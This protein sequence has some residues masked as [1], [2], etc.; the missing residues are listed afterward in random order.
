MTAETPDRLDDRRLARNPIAIV[1][2]SGLFP[3]ARNHREYW[4]NIVDGIDCTEDVPESRWSLDEY[5]DE[6]RTAPDKTYSRRGA[7]LPDVDFDPLEFGL[8][9]NQ[10]EVTSTMQTLSLGVARDLLTDAGAPDS[11]WYDPS[12]TGVVLGI[13]GPVP[14]MHPLAARLSTPV[15]KEVARSCGLSDTDANVLADKFVTAFAPWEENSFPGL[16]ANVVAGR[17]ANRFGLGGINCT[18]DAACAASLAAMRTA[19]AELLDGR[20]DTMITGGVDT[21]NSIFIYM[22]F[23]KVGALSPTGRISPFSDQANGTLL[24]EGISMLALRRLEDAERDGNRIY[25]VIKGLGSSSDGRSKSIYAPRAEG[26]RVA[27]DRAYTDADCSPAS[28]ELFEAHATGTA[29]GD[30]TELTALGGLLADSSDEHRFAALGSVKSQIGHTKGAAGTASVMKLALGLYHRVL[31]GTINVDKP[32]PAIDTAAA[33]Y[34]INTRTRP[35]IRDPQ[36]PVRRAA[37]SAM[38]FGGTNFHVVL[39][40]HANPAADRRTLHTAPTAHLW[41]AP[42]VTTLTDLVR[43]RPSQDGGQIPTDHVRIG[44][45]SLDDDNETHLRE[46]AADQLAKNPDAKAWNHPEGIFY[47]AAAQP[48]LRIGALFSGQGSQ[49]VDMGTAAVLANPLVADTFD[50]ANAAFAGEPQRLG[51]V[52]FPPPVFDDSD[53]D[54]QEALLRRTEFAQPAIGALSAGQFRALTELGFHA[55]G[56]LGHSFGE[57]TALW[58]AGSLTTDD[59]FTLARARG[60][61]MAPQ[62]GAETGTMLAV[63]ATRDDVDTLIADLDDV[64]VCNHNA[65]DQIVVGGGAEAVAAFARTCA[66]RGF[67]TR[68]LPVSA[69]FHTPYVGHAV[70]AFEP[71]VAEV[72]IGEPAAP[73]YAN[74]PGAHYG[75]DIDTNRATLVG[76]LL[77]PVEFVTA[78]DSMRQA[79]CTVFV[80]FG[81][82]QVLTSLVRRTLGDDVV[83]IAT[84]GGPLGDSDLSL[85]RAAV[86][87]A[88]LGLALDG[89]NRYQDLPPVPVERRGMSVSLSAPE[90]IPEERRRA[91][92]DAL[93]D[94]YRVAPVTAPAASTLEPTATHPAPLPIPPAPPVTAAATPMPFRATENT[95]SHPAGPSTGLDTALSQ[96][97]A[98]HNDYLDGQLELARE[99]ARALNTAQLDNGMVRAIEA[100]KD[101]G[102]A[103]SHT[104]A[105]ATEILGHL[106]ELDTPAATGTTVAVSSRVDLE[107]LPTRPAPAPTPAPAPAPAPIPAPVP[108]PTPAAAPPAPTTP[109]TPTAPPATTAPAQP[110]AVDAAALRTALQEVVADKTGYPVEMVDPSMDL[111]ADLGVDSIKRV[112]V[113]GAVQERFPHLPSLGPEQ[114]GTLRTLDQI[115]DLLADTAAPAA[116]TT[117]PTSSPP[118]GVDA[119]VLR[120]ALQEVVADKTGYPVEMVD[121]SMDLEADLGVD[122]IKRVQVLGAVQERFPHLPSL[123]PEQLGTLRTLD[124]IVDL[125][126]EGS[127]VHPKAEAAATAPRHLVELVALP[128]IDHQDNTFG[129]HPHAVVI[130]LGPDQESSDG[131]A[132]AD[133][134]TNHHWTVRRIP[135]TGTLDDIDT[136]LTGTHDERTDLCIVTVGS[137]HD[138]AEA[139]RALGAT[140]LA[141]KHTHPALLNTARTGTR[142]AFVTVT[143]IDGALG[144]VGAGDPV[145]ALAGGVGGVVKTL[146]VEHPE[147]FSRAL[148][149]HPALDGDRFTTAVLAELHDSAVDTPE[150]GVGELGDRQTLVPGI[151][152]GSAEQT[153][154]H[155]NTPVEITALTADDVVLVTGGARGVTALC[156][157]DLARHCDARFILLGR[158]ELVPEPQWAHGVEDQDLRRAAI[159]GLGGTATTPREIARTCAAITANREI[160]DTLT[161]LGERGRYIAA[162]VTDTAAIE[163]ALGADRD[164]ITA[165]VHGAGVLADALIAKKTAGEIARVL[166]PKVGGLAAVLGALG[167]TAQLRHLV[168]FTSVAGLYGN[169]GQVDYA[170]ANEALGRFAATW[171]H[172]HPDHHVTAI[173]WGAWDGGMVTPELRGYFLDRGI[174][175]LDPDVGARAFTEQFTTARRDDVVILIGEAKSLATGQPSHRPDTIVRRNLSD[176]P[177]HRIIAAHRIGDHT[178]LPATFGLGAMINVV[179]RAHPG[180]CVTTVRDFRVHKGIVFDHPITDV[181]IETTHTDDNEPVRVHVQVFGT[182]NDRRVPHYAATFELSTTPDSAPAVPVTWPTTGADAEILYRDA[183]QFH[184]PPLQGMRR[185]LRDDADALVLECALSGAPVALGAFTGVLHNPVLADVILQGPP[186]AG[187]RALGSACLPLGIGRIDYYDALPDDEPFVLIVDNARRGPVD[188]LVDACAVTANGTVL[189]RFTDVTV[190]TTPDLSE[191]F[192]ES[193]RQWSA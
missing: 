97:V 41:H 191:K 83:A 79:G 2:M 4:Q 166:N 157:R 93:A 142:A 102:V 103:I 149:I 58:A 23:S 129:D 21:E 109:A 78:L 67:A 82:K 75:T 169:S 127:D 135:L 100:I 105:R 183:T 178:V 18:V 132:I 177:A 89:I 86:Q 63:A 37:A 68:E 54:T 114:L 98:T 31:P 145:G 55:D 152:A 119:A 72:R 95:V 50:R 137:T 43:S 173:D 8:P 14:L 94:G 1:G 172:R 121:P 34:Y 158:T 22:C 181:S 156:V 90:Y 136:T 13:T 3:K 66:D 122:S 154:V 153:S 143:R 190:V 125:L 28:V 25:A 35:W 192:R 38:G 26:Q 134:L 147:L 61:A 87:L 148:D 150:V 81:P 176:L 12:R 52:V 146:G 69:A 17:I 155:L 10:L 170:A 159:A 185:I 141:A 104:H 40:E 77:Q 71:A 126:A 108:A 161:V 39:E 7:F 174:T 139:T 124:Q 175:L 32:N 138:W 96:H 162:D 186:V 64:W 106:A 44:F 47:R 151:H 120:T 111:E 128:P 33:P 179:E 101:H 188:A 165:L 49:Y 48:D 60:R 84:D 42:D 167:E 180:L 168:F 163:A 131:A 20:A 80:E 29:V 92:A 11:T 24:G 112:Q 73:V 187:H 118:A 160:Q 15:L 16:L 59:F 115:V 76:Q 182:E 116:P 30:R 193:V 57:L 70:A 27:L 9:P 113:L 99:L 144:F 36:R 5:Y 85:K 53:R 6:D 117:T 88:V 19:I 189:Q 74:S 171:K 46:L 184:A 91:Y 130:E 164:Q 62:P 45:V 123:G 65:A 110:A 56:Y 140:I 51:A 107:A 133:A